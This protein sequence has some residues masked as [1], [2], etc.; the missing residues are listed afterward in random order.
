MCLAAV[1]LGVATT[2]A[3]VVIPATP[4]KFTKRTLSETGSNGGGISFGPTNP[5]AE[6]KVRY[7]THVALSDSRQW[8]S[9]DGKS[10]LGKLIAFEDITVETAKGAPAPSSPTMPPSPTVVKDGK[11]RLLVNNKPAEVPLERL[12]QPDRDFIENI[13]TAVAKKAATTPK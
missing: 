5:P 11:A 2:S 1:L 12:S 8:Q 7:I 6:A 3:Q 10:I 9:S 4:K 13:R